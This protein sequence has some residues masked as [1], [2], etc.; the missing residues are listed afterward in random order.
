MA[1]HSE[2]ILGLQED[3]KTFSTSP[4]TLTDAQILLHPVGPFTPDSPVLASYGH[5][6]LG[7]DVFPQS[8]PRKSGSR[9]GQR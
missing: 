7:E 6:H 1:A 4:L 9:V 8:V 3:S 2:S 5:Q